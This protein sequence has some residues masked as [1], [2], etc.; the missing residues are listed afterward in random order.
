MKKYFTTGC[1]CFFSLHK[2]TVT[3]IPANNRNLTLWTSFQWNENLDHIPKITIGS[4]RGGGGGGIPVLVVEEA[5][6]KYQVWLTEAACKFLQVKSSSLDSRR[7]CWPHMYSEMYLHGAKRSEWVQL[8]IFI[9]GYI[10]KL[11]SHLIRDHLYCIAYPRC[12]CTPQAKFTAG[13]PLKTLMLKLM[14]L[15]QIRATLIHSFP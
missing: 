8:Q 9:K 11:N 15:I 5:E 7:C 12:S 14:Y 1:Q 6:S 3:M 2:L 10:C 13:A 4:N